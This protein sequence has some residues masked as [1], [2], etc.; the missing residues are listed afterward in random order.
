LPPQW[1]TGSAFVQGIAKIENNGLCGLID[2]QGKQVTDVCF[3]KIEKVLYDQLRL[4]V[5]FP[6]DNHLYL[7]SFDGS[8]IAEYLWN[9]IW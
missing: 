8:V 2:S 7:V 1:D 4:V 5:R 6:S 3:A 9:D